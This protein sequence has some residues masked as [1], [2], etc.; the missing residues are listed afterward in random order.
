M[1]NNRLYL[2]CTKCNLHQYLAKSFGDGWSTSPHNSMNDLFV[3]FMNE[4]FFCSKDSYSK[5]IELHW[6]NDDDPAPKAQ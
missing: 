4:H 3:D 6:E 1:A 2:Y 5:A